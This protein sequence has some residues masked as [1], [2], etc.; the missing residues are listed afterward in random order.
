MREGKRKATKA[1]VA[2]DHVSQATASL[3][4]HERQI[5]YCRSR[6]AAAAAAAE[7]RQSKSNRLKNHYPITSQRGTKMERAKT[8]ICL[9][10]IGFENNDFSN[11][12]SDGSSQT[13]SSAEK[14]SPTSDANQTRIELWHVM[15][16]IIDQRFRHFIV[17]STAFAQRRCLVFSTHMLYI[18]IYYIQKRFVHSYFQLPL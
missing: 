15:R 6:A 10:S 7:A 8:E 18:C 14:A 2:R 13:I 9:L 16:V 5:A 17:G 3:K 4:L 1:R 11:S 12:R